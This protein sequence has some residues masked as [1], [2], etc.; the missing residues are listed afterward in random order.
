[1]AKIDLNKALIIVLL[2]LAAVISILPVA[3]KMTTPDTYLRTINSIDDKVE[4]V[5]KLTATSTLASAAVSAI[6]G[7]TATPIAEKLADFTEY[8]LIVLCVLYAEKYLLTI[9]GAGV[10]RILIP[11]VCLFGIISLFRDTKALQRLAVKLTVIGLCICITV[12]VSIRVSDMIY[13]TYRVSIDETISSAETF[14]GDTAELAEAEDA[15]MIQSILSKI[16]ESVTS[17]SE[18]AARVLNRFVESL[19]VLIV[20]SCVIPLLVLVFF[21]WLIRAVTGVQI[22]VPAPLQRLRP[23]KKRKPISDTA[24]LK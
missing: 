8:F 5:L 20:T 19:A 15:G 17:L 18:R 6:P 9:V 1:M 11:L 3:D 12:P 24:L 16:S 4:T 22:T 23:K 7:D 13:E 21:L 14:S 2:L 10:F